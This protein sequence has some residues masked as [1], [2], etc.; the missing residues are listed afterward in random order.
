[1]IHSCH[2]PGTPLSHPSHAPL[3]LVI[4]PCHTPVTPLT[5][6]P[7]FYHTPDTAATIPLSYQSRT[8]DTPVA[9]S[10]N[11]CHTS[12]WF[13]CVLR[14][15]QRHHITVP[16]Q[17][18]LYLTNASLGMHGSTKLK[19]PTVVCMKTGAESSASPVCHLDATRPSSRLS[20]WLECPTKPTGAR[21]S[22][23]VAAGEDASAHVYTLWVEGAVEVHVSGQHTCPASH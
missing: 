20:L 19:Q 22:S 8:C 21:A 6:L 5:H 9:L 1:M 4:Y 11:L 18:Q 7:H 13:A 14:P 3:I 17:H 15:G 23:V 16:R 10:T 2:T 12:G